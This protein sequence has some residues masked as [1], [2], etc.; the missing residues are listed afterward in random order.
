LNQHFTPSHRPYANAY[1]ARSGGPGSAAAPTACCTK[2]EMLAAL[3]ARTRAWTR[4]S[5]AASV[6]VT[7][8]VAIPL[9]GRPK[10]ADGGGRRRRPWQAVTTA[11]TTTK[12]RGVPRSSCTEAR[13]HE[14]WVPH[15][16]RDL[17]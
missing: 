1:G 5:C 4:S 11:S 8:L 9:A 7:F 12:G 3:P 15:G 6:M 16:R 14:E 17:A 2:P 13:W 10:V